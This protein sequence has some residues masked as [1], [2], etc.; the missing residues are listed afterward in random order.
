MPQKKH[1]ETVEEQ[2]ERF[3]QAVQAMVDAGELSP[4]EADANFDRAMS[5]VARLRQAWFDGEA[6]SET[7][8]SAP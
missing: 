3:R 4:T 2:A 7:D 5:G 6:A 1:K 8:P